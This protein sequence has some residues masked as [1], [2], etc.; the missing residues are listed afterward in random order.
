MRAPSVPASTTWLMGAGGVCARTASSRCRTGMRLAQATPLGCETLA[1]A[2][3]SLRRLQSGAHG[4][5]QLA[6]GTCV[7]LLCS[8]A[9]RGAMAATVGDFVQDGCSTAAV[10]GLSRQIVAEM[11]CIAPGALAVLVEDG[12]IV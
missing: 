12:G 5:V 3:R 11:N 4:R 2:R 8:V 10:D 7:V 6:V 9:G 1:K